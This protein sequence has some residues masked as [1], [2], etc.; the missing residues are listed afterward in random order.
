M[1]FN[2]KVTKTS[3]AAKVNQA[4]TSLAKKEVYV[5]IPQTRSSR[6]GEPINNAELMYIHTNG[7]PVQHI[8]ARPV[9][10]PAIS[11]PETRALIVDELKLA[12]EAALT[13]DK[14]K[15]DTHLKRAGLIGSNAAKAWFTDSRN[16]WPKNKPSTIRNK[17]RKLRGKSLRDALDILDEYE[18]DST[19]DV[20]SIDTPLIDTG[21]LRRSITFVVGEKGK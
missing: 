6:P 16:N 5:G 20:S 2:V 7:S 1:A 19:T 12:A 17:I 3:S 11:Q 4:L 18:Q 8:P 21:E 10:E 9:I 13:G 14:G 15:E